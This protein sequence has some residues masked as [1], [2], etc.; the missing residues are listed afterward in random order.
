MGAQVKG[1]RMQDQDY[2]QIISLCLEHRAQGNNLSVKTELSKKLWWKALLAA[3]F[4]GRGEMSF[5]LGS[6][7]FMSEEAERVIAL[8]LD[9]RDFVLSLEHIS[10]E[11]L[12]QRLGDFID[13]AEA[14]GGDISLVEDE[15]D[16][17][18]IPIGERLLVDRHDVEFQLEGMRWFLELRLE[19][20]EAVEAE[21]SMFRK[22]LAV[23]DEAAKA[24]ISCFIPYNNLRRSFRERFPDPVRFWWWHM[25][26]DCDFA[27]IYK[28]VEG[29]EVHSEHLR[30]C[31]DC[32]KLLRELRYVRMALKSAKGMPVE[33]PDPEKLVALYYG[34]IG[35]LEKRAIEF[36][37]KLCRSCAA[38]FEMIP[39]TED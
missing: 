14:A 34:Q 28:V 12:R 6:E 26:A 32:Q 9:C 20:K 10:L 4:S 17:D 29:K 15:E 39:R 33:H 36:H 7:G 25:R 35:G 2:K 23:F 11:R 16:E 1:G 5:L 3:L 13:R 27:P 19:L 21:F 37:L 24:A 31:G 22:R 18:V 8:S 38:E 30:S